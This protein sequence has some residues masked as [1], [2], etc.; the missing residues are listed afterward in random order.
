MAKR[1]ERIE[2]KIFAPGSKITVTPDLRGAVQPGSIA[3]VAFFRRGHKEWVHGTVIKIIIIRRGKGGQNRIESRSI[4]VPTFFID[5]DEKFMASIP[6][7]WKE[8][9]NIEL[10][11]VPRSLV[12]SSSM[13]FLGWACA[14]TNF[15]YDASKQ[16]NMT[17]AWP[18]DPDDP[19]NICLRLES[20]FES[21]PQAILAKAKDR[22]LRAD[23]VIGIR[24]LEARLS[25]AV[26]GYMSKV[27]YHNV[28]MC[29]YFEKFNND[30]PV[31]TKS[32]IN[33]S[34]KYFED[35]YRA[36]STL[37]HI[38]DNRMGG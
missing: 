38:R 11:P 18:A 29:S 6:T 22:E 1:I 14:Y 7:G 13:D 5:G 32:A 4:V 30:V 10:V 28:R 33:R 25:G 20:H 9:M 31:V 37:Q 15:L 17:H 36:V 27:S 34:N 35:E 19:V 23:L 24:A 16:Y 3:F 26:L 8:L 21:K 12:A 2:S